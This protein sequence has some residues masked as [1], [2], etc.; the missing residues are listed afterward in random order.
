MEFEE[1]AWLDDEPAFRASS[2]VDGEFPERVTILL[3]YGVAK[4]DVPV[5]DAG[6]EDV[7]KAVKEM[8]RW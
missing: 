7:S 2:S 3:S 1:F 6:Y 8:A 5:D 4:V